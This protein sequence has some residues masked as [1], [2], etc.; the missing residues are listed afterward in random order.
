MIDLRNKALPDSVI[1]Q[2]KAYLIHTDYRVWLEFSERLK[3]DKLTYADLAFVFVDKI[4]NCDFFNELMSFYSNRNIT[5][6]NLGY[7]G[8]DAIMYDYIQ[9]GEYIYA[10]FI[11]EYNID[12]IDTDMHWWKF[13]A[14]FC[15]LSN[16]SKMGQ[17]MGYR[18]YKKSNK[19]ASKEYERLRRIWSLDDI[20][21][22]EEIEVKDVY[23]S[24]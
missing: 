5:P 7:T 16:D 14:L 11:K 2:G 15:S 6:V 13:K 17:I 22:K 12:L 4:P 8:S 1:V 24:L 18:G 10:S 3:K 20:L 19:E 9:D 21:T 23:D